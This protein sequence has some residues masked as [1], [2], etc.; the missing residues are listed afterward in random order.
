MSAG[1]AV[2]LLVLSSCA[3]GTRVATGPTGQEALGVVAAPV[4]IDSCLVVVETV[5]V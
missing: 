2:V 4:A 3:N 5:S 1:L